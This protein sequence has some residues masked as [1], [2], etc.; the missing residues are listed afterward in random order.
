MRTA[1]TRLRLLARRY[2]AILAASLV[3]VT[4][5]SSAH[6]GP[7]TGAAMK[8]MIWLETVTVIDD[9][10]D[11]GSG[12]VFVFSRAQH[13]GHRLQRKRF[14]PY[15]VESGQAF[16]L[17]DEIFSHARCIPPPDGQTLRVKILDEDVTGWDTILD[18]GVSSQRLLRLGVYA[19]S[20]SGAR[21]GYIVGYF[22]DLGAD[23]TP[24]GEN[25][26]EEDDEGEGEEEDQD[27][28]RQEYVHRLDPSIGYLAPGGDTQIRVRL[29]NRSA[30]EA[31]L[32]AAVEAP[33]LLDPGGEGEPNEELRQADAAWFGVS[34]A[35]NVRLAPGGEATFTLTASV[36]AS[37]AP[38]IYAYRIVFSQAGKPLTATAGLLRVA[39]APAPPR[40]TRIADEEP[41]LLD[42]F[43][44]GP[45]VGQYQRDIW[46]REAAIWILG[47]ALL[48]LLAWVASRRRRSR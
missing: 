23:C 19:L 37:A 11:A 34:P 13:D 7:P 18:A 3:A 36:P 44:D 22:P 16:Y 31:R 15:D 45:S 4:F 28:Y 48:A 10:D 6:Y 30:G 2:P 42:P 41:A 29:L 8:A 40:L 1:R 32:S 24:P 12:E 38:G 47:A 39:R 33:E 9:Q 27:P 17:G 26:D 46:R 20:G 35:G 25:G 43:F 14:G 5:P 21:V